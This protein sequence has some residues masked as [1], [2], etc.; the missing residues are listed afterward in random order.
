MPAQVTAPG[1]DQKPQYARAS[2]AAKHLYI[3]KNTLWQWAGP[4]GL[5]GF[6]KPIKAG[7]KVSLFDLTAIEACLKDQAPQVA[8]QVGPMAVEAPVRKPAKGTLM[9]SGA[10]RSC[11]DPARAPFRPG[12][13]VHREGSDACHSAVW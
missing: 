1:A 13:G 4:N 5:V 7:P 12:S 9:R 3:G 2:A 11:L 10:E 8:G 6:P